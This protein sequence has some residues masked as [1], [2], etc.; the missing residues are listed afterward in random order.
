M[1][2]FNQTEEVLDIQ[3]TQYGKRLLAKGRFK[4]RYYAFFDKD[5]VYNYDWIKLPGL[6]GEAQ[7]AA[8][9]RIKDETARLKVQHN[10][11]GVET[12]FNEMKEII[13]HK[14]DL[15]DSFVEQAL[16]DAENAFFAIATTLGT[17]K[18][19]SQYNPAWQIKFYNE[20]LGSS[21]WAYSGSGPIIRIPQIEA[22]NDFFSYTVDDIEETGLQSDLLAGDPSAHEDVDFVVFDDDSSI[23]VEKNFILLGIEE[24]NTDFYSENFE[25]EVFMVEDY[26]PNEKLTLANTP[27]EKLIPLTFFSYEKSEELNIDLDINPENDPSFV[28]YF[29]D[30]T[31]DDEIPWSILCAKVHEDDKKSLYVRKI[32]TC[33]DDEEF[34]ADSDI[35]KDDEIGDACE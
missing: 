35:Y 17:T 14:D 31:V 27:S 23:L 4:P 32:F 33:P 7:N 19:K 22:K 2:F 1:E 28:E 6:P 13:K 24:K 9:T 20:S 25:I 8:E 21:N 16:Q 18:L 11:I 3:L 15:S 29:L 12:Q 5:I 30:I 10:Y 26:F 34:L